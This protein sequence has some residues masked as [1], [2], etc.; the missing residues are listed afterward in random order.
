MIR[1][2]DLRTDSKRQ[3][4]NE[5]KDVVTVQIESSICFVRAI[6]S[7]TEATTEPSRASEEITPV[8]PLPSKYESSQSLHEP[9]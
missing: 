6:R 4:R 2:S 7:E 8:P 3:S 1:N 9:C 5:A